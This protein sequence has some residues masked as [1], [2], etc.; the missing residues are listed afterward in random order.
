MV[1]QQDLNILLTCGYDGSFL[2][3][4]GHIHKGKKILWHTGMAQDPKKL[5]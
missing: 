2:I 3:Y 5:T 4:K 1:S